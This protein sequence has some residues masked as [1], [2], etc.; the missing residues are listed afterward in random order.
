MGAEAIQALLAQTDLAKL[1][2]ELDEQMDATRCK[3]IRKK[4]AKRLKLVQ[5][6]AN[7]HTRPEWMI[8]EVLPVIPPDLAPAGSARRRTFRDVGFERSLPPGHQSQ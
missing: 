2:K 6:F 7:S 1:N 5:G 3:Q 4:L 8:L